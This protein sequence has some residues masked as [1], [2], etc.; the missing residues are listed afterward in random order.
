MS[1][2]SIPRTFVANVDGSRVLPHLE[3][4]SGNTEN[5]SYYI[6]LSIL[7]HSVVIRTEF[8]NEVTNFITFSHNYIS[9][10]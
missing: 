4:R 9:F 7:S 2:S 5:Y 6:Y 3:F 1:L 10:I 8:N